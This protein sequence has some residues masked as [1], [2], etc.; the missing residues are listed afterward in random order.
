MKLV[1]IE[2]I[3]KKDTIKKYLGSDYEVMATKGHIRDLPEKE[4]GV[5]LIKNF[6]PNYQIINDKKEIV[7]ELKKKA[8][9]AD[10]IYL[11]TDP[12]REGEAI[13]WHL[14][15]I[16]GLDP[17]SNIR[18]TFNEISKNAV[19][20]GLQNPRS[21][22]KNLFDAQQA[23]RVLDRIV[24]YK[25][26]P[27]ICKK[28]APKLS[29]GRVQS[30]ALKLVVDR[31]REILNFKPEDYYVFPA[32]FYKN[33]EKENFKAN[34]TKV[35]GKKI[36]PKL[37]A[38]RVQ[39]AA[40]KLVVDR[41]REILNFKPEDYYV[42]PAVFYKNNEK[43]NFKANL[44]KVDGKKLDCKNEDDANLIVEEL[45]K[46]KYIVSSVK[47]SMGKT[48]PTPPYTTSTMQQDALNKLNFNLK[49]TTKLAQSLYEGVDIEGHGKTALVTYIRS[50][51]VR[52]AP[53]A[54]TMARNFILNNFGKEY[55]PAKENVYKT[56]SQAQ[57]AHEAIRPIN[58]DLTP[59]S[60]KGKIK[61]EG[62]DD[63]LKLYE[64]IYN[65]FLACQMADSTYNSVVVEINNGK[66]TFKA[67]GKT[68][69]FDGF[70]KVYA[71]KNKK[72]KLVDE[73]V[74][75]EAND[76]IPALNENDEVFVLDKLDKV[77]KT[78]KPPSRFTEATLVKEMEEKGIGRPATYT[79]TITV[80][81]SR[82]YT[83]K[84]GKELKPTS[85]GMSVVDFLEKYF[86]NV[87]NVK[88]T[89][90][91][92]SNLDKIA[93]EGI[94]WQS[95]IK[96]FYTD[97]AKELV[98]A[99]KDSVKIKVE[100]KQTDQV[101]EKCGSPMVIRTGKFGEF[102]ACSNYPTCKN[103]ASLNKLK[104]VAKCPKCGKP[105]YER[106]SKKGAIY[107]GCSGYPECDFIS[108]E[109]PLDEKCPK[110]NS[111]LTYKTIYGNIRKKCSNTSCDYTITIPKDKKE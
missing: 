72:K 19:T 57:D 91:M 103:V 76:K 33:N 44:T 21:I 74:E 106:K 34:L 79:P 42:F 87:I 8:S 88:F 28:I 3:G 50:D 18:V 86:S 67:I 85:L 68:P 45:N 5:N 101:C 75:E 83:E 9:E 2:G 82:N 70:T 81:A 11:A 26:S 20:N 35:D 48:H 1:V 17:N 16:L 51:S 54:I 71:N 61:S 30:A 59:S 73:T 49:K 38:G 43:E 92:E 64:M 12:D 111:Y 4:F 24:G 78:T 100:P 37:S 52:I 6:E 80:L 60:L 23:R 107:Y 29:A 109:I 7:Q 65:K 93:E 84:D 56:K 99:D 95:V 90:Q 105:V 15:Y 31:E 58:L 108:W 47:K 27:I 98:A 10:S 77:K 94:E 63:L 53:E 102:L 13:S 55:L 25:L 62:A 104:E 39:S 89:A 96:D 22:N 46:G 41:E 66:Y 40:L 97:F 14:A 69:L 110:C 32:V 36:A